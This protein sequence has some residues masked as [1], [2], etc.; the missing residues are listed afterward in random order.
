MYLTPANLKATQIKLYE[1][2]IVGDLKREYF[3][4]L[5]R[6]PTMNEVL[7]Q[8]LLD[9]AEALGYERSKVRKSPTWQD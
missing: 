9:K 6:T 5:S 7:Y 4:V 2:V 3:W 8:E 1:W